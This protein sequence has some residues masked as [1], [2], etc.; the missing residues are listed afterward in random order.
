MT[1]ED[2]RRD[3][4]SARRINGHVPPVE[5]SKR[6]LPE[7]LDVDAFL[8]LKLPPREFVLA[9][10][11]P[12]KG[13]AMLYGERGLGKTHVAVGIAH[14]VASAGSIFQ[15]HA[16]EPRS[17]L[18]VDGEMPAE[19]LQERLKAIV[20]ANEGAQVGSR[21][22][23]LAAD[24]HPEP[25]PAL[26]D[27]EGQAWLEG[28]WGAQPE[29]LIFDNLS[30]LTSQVRDNEA[31]SWTTMQRWLLSLRRKGMAVLFVHH[32]AKGGQQRGTSRR[33]DLLDTTIKLLKPK[34]YSPRDG[35]RF[36][37]HL[38]K[39]RGVFGDDAEPF[40]A[41]LATESG[42]TRWTRKKLEDAR[43][44]QARALF[45]KGSTVVEVAKVLE[46]SKS[47]AGRLRRRADYEPTLAEG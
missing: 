8:S 1:H 13:L 43:L 16:P 15:W 28:N 22:R 10:I 17:V 3:F 30:A 23:L 37:V 32:A 9:P 40:E 45:A 26:A 36:E 47:A 21:L 18:Y 39:V 27:P 38:D 42:L 44:V 12:A 34:D 19:T 2:V 24:R 35:A 46:I 20:A 4:A 31:D 33:E 41:S 29:L 5:Q 14:A 6:A 7:I 25:L 11:L